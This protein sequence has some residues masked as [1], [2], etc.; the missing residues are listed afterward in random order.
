L[1]TEA[2]A[3]EGRTV[4][5]LRPLALAAILC[6]SFTTPVLASA[7]ESASYSQLVLDDLRELESKFVQLADAIPAEHYGW[8]PHV[9]VRS[10]GELLAHAASVT[11]FSTQ[12]LGTP[13]PKGAFRG[14][15]NPEA[16]TAKEEVLSFLSS[17][18]AHAIAHVSVHG[19]EPQFSSLDMLVHLHEHLG[20]AIA[21]SRSLGVKPPWS[22][23]HGNH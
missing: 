6:I 1:P 7:A 4:F 15:P 23:R 3:K 20:Q 14:Q 2:T 10:V 18:F 17:A 16:I 19:A 12:H 5:R 13:I 8:R 21:Y 9:E 11:Y 22:G